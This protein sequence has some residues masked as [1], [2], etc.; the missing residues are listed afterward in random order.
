LKKW[1]LLSFIVA[2]VLFLTACTLDPFEAYEN[3]V[4]DLDVNARIEDAFYSVNQGDTSPFF[5]SSVESIYYDLQSF[6]A[7]DD[8][9]V[10]ASDSNPPQ[11]DYPL[12]INNDYTECVQKL[13]DTINDNVADDPLAAKSDFD[14][15]L[16][17]YAEAQNLY[18][19]FVID[20][21]HKNNFT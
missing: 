19:Q 17:K 4:T 10:P 16:G 14:Q 9:T 7:E 13:L 8:G 3:F 11:I 15:A 20:Y 18:Q 21:N 12:V 1:A 2:A 6:S 5:R